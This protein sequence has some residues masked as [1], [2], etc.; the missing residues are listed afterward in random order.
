MSPGVRWIQEVF[1]ISLTGSRQ[2]LFGAIYSTLPVNWNSILVSGSLRD[3]QKSS[4]REE[5]PLI[6]APKLSLCRD[7]K[8]FFF[9]S[10][11][12]IY[13]IIFR[14]TKLVIFIDVFTGGDCI[15][16][17]QHGSVGFLGKSSRTN[18]PK[19]HL[20]PT[21]EQKWGFSHKLYLFWDVEKK[22]TRG[23]GRFFQPLA[24]LLL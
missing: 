24:F 1:S 23:G 2:S 9:Q 12:L 18:S 14:E 16:L 17:K 20:F 21:S 19:L 10:T 15:E 5:F 13:K 6:L 8:V 3:Y 22:P 7:T 11:K 4:R